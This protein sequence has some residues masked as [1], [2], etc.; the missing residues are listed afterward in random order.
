WVLGLIIK[1][2]SGIWSLFE[3][4]GSLF[5]K[6][7]KPALLRVLI[8][9]GAAAFALL[10]IIPLL[11]G[12]DQMFGH[13]LSRIFA[14]FSLPWIAIHAI[15]ITIVFGLLY[16]LWWN[17]GF[18]SNEK[19]KIPETWAIDPLISGIVLGSILAV[20]VLFVAVMSTYLFAG[21]GLPEGMTYAQYAR[22]GFAQTVAVCALNL[23]LFG[24]FLK[25]GKKNQNV[26]R[27]LLTCLLVLTGLMLFSGGVRLHLY[28]DTFGMTWLRLLSLWFLIYLTVVVSLCAIRLFKRNFPVLPL[29]A[30][31]LLVW[32]V[33][34]GFLNP[35]GFVVWFNYDLMEGALRGF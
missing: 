9:V 27:I 8:G 4:F 15:I 17:V 33:V 1:P 2:F 29:A 30:L 14:S 19:H 5:A 11:M 16:S 12:A 6:A 35:D 7:N 24:V 28:I 3:A 32:F 21:A 18:G 25:L 26:T 34:L 22:A 13:H 10:I 23:G 20:Y 31:I